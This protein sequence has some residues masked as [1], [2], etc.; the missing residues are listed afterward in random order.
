MKFL[1]GV[2]F[3]LAVCS[4]ASAQSGFTPI[5]WNPHNTTLWNLYSDGSEFAQMD[6]IAQGQSEWVLIQVDNVAVQQVA[7][8]NNYQFNVE[9]INN[10]AQTLNFVIHDSPLTLLSWSVN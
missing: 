2:I 10:G 9:I 1:I 8:G 6:A 7:N 5:Q 4:F 3:A